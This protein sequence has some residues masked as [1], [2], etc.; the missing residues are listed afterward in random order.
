MAQPLSSILGDVV[1]SSRSIAHSDDFEG[2]KLIQTNS[3]Q[4][5]LLDL[6]ILYWYPASR[7]QIKPLL[8]QPQIS[9]NASGLAVANPIGRALIE[10]DIRI[11]GPFVF[12]N[13]IYG[14]RDVHHCRGHLSRSFLSNPPRNYELEK[15]LHSI[16]GGKRGRFCRC[17]VCAVCCVCSVLRRLAV[18]A[19]LRDGVRWCD[20]AQMGNTATQPRYATAIQPAKNNPSLC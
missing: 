14:W 18:S 15:N 6:N 7:D 12:R 8:A 2:H 1:K 5:I 17:S 4:L 9:C 16:A 19:V 10:D 11:W 3:R 20:M 13:Q